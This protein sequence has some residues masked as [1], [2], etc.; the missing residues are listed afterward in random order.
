MY[1]FVPTFVSTKQTYMKNQQVNF[2]SPS[3]LRVSERYEEVYGKNEAIDPLLKETIQKEG[4]K[5]PIIITKGKT[6]VS[7]VLRWR[8]AMAL[9][10]NPQHQRKF[11]VIPVIYTDSEDTPKEI[12]IHNQGRTKTYTQKL[13]EFKLLKDE[14]L[15]GRGYRSDMTIDRVKNK[16]KLEDILGESNSTLNRLL[17]IDANIVKACQGNSQQIQKKWELLD[18]GKLSV[19]GLYNWIKDALLKN[20]VS[21][22]KEYK[23]GSIT[24]LNQSC[25]D[26]SCLQ[27]KSVNCF[28]TSPPYYKMATYENGSDELGQ[29]KDIDTYIKKLAGLLNGV[30]DKLAANGSVIVN[31]SDTVKKGEHCLIP[32]RLVLEMNRMGWKVRNSL[33]WLKTNPPFSGKDVRPN[34]SHEYIFQFYVGE[35]PYYNASWLKE[36]G[37][38]IKHIQYGNEKKG[39]VNLKSAWNFN[40]D[41][42]SI[43][44][45]VNNLTPI[46]K[47]FAQ[48]QLK[49]TH[50]AMMNDVVAG[51]LLRTFVQKGG[52]V[53]DIFNGLNTTG[54][55]CKELGINFIGFE[56]NPDFFSQSITRTKAAKI[57]NQIV[58][59]IQYAA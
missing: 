46:K 36:K 41:S 20:E 23:E 12:I 54:L 40:I 3:E 47:L 32:H 35:A 28:L 56:I 21:E 25:A 48:Q 31:I 24:L 22:D 17:S 44:T 26:L 11:Q 53:V 2:I 49:M 42:D 18:S 45:A 38:I 58:E 30:K 1:N 10:Q 29:E 9:S 8:I 34:P 5:E 51:I 14:F 52:T 55:R 33:V 37:N 16:E 15:P 6:I 39:E 19:T 27:K 4:I 59:E 43:E 13:K 7:G 57:K 50:P